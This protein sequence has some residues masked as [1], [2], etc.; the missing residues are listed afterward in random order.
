MRILAIRGRNLASLPEFALEL[1]RPPLYETGIFA[2]TGP[3]GAGKSTLLDALCLALYDR[4]PRLVGTRGVPTEE[5]G[6]GAADARGLL[7]RGTG[8]GFAEVDFVGVDGAHYRARWEVWRARRQPEGRLQDQRVALYHLPAEGPPKDLSEGRRTDT[9][10]AI[11][12][13]VGLEFDAFRR[14]VLLAQGDFA[15]FLRARP[16]ERAALLE[17]MTGTELYAELSRA[18]FARARDVRAELAEATARIEAIQPLAERA[19]A[20]LEA[21]SEHAAAAAREAEVQTEAHRRSAEWWRLH[22]GLKAELD[23][24]LDQR[25]AARSAASELPSLRERLG[26]LDALQR[27]R[28]KLEAAREADTRLEATEIEHRAATRALEA[29]TGHAETAELE[30]QQAQAAARRATEARQIA[31]PELE[32]ARALD[33]A[34]ADREAALARATAEREK[35]EAERAKLEARWAALDERRRGFEAAE[36]EDRGWWQAHA[37]LQDLDAAAQRLEASEARIAGQRRLADA[38]QR[39]ADR[40][41]RIE[42]A[43]AEAEKKRA[44]LTD[45]ESAHAAAVRA[46]RVAEQAV[47]EA[48]EPSG[49]AAARVLLERLGS[50]VRRLREGMAERRRRRREAAELEAASEALP[51]TEPEDPSQLRIDLLGSTLAGADAARARD[52]LLVPEQPC[53]LCGSPHHPFVD[54][55]PAPRATDPAEVGSALEALGEARARA[56]ALAERRARLDAESAKDRD[57]LERLRTELAELWLESS[58]LHGLGLTRVGLLLPRRPPE[59]SEQLGRALEALEEVE[60]KF[61]ASQQRGV[62]AKEALAAARL[63]A[64]G[65]EG[66]LGEARIASQ[67]AERALEE[68]RRALL[69]A[70]IQLGEAKQTLEAL[71]P[72]PE[73]PQSVEEAREELEHAR[74]R[75]AEA[76][77]RAGRAEELQRR[78]EEL[79]VELQRQRQRVQARVDQQAELHTQR[80]A[81]REAR[82]QLL[83]GAPTDRVASR[84]EAA[85]SEA[86]SAL[87]ASLDRRAGVRVTLSEARTSARLREEAHREALARATK[88]RSALEAALEAEAPRPPETLRALAAQPLEASEPLERRIATL[89]AA[90]ARAETTTA[91]RSDR[92]KAHEDLR[93]AQGPDTLEAAEQALR[94][95]ELRLQRSRDDATRLRLEREKDDEA[96]AR[97]LALEAPLAEQSAQALVWEELSDLIGSADGKKLRAFA[98]SLSLDALVTRANAHL[99]QL[100]PRYRLQRVTRADMELEVVDTDMGDEVRPIA[101]LSG[102]ETFLVSL[103][104]ALGLSD[105]SSAQIEV[106]SLF[107]D[108][109]FGALDPES[110]DVVLTALDQ[111]QASGR[112]VAMVSH[113]ADVAERLGFEVRVRPVAPGRSEV[114]VRG[115]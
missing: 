87:E 20:Q 81:E 54:A 61:D 27:I 39:C 12:S 44:A 50:E 55:P 10:K 23:A 32:K 71:G 103:A 98:Q 18:A 97:R 9:S 33:A 14:A 51:A 85:E 38:A 30:A 45:R 115:P 24:A 82:S 8:E 58:L 89:E 65:S 53:P 2:I 88:A 60:A 57:K 46:L 5:D 73:G 84:L 37:H 64:T 112:R 114:R 108:E 99:T 62:Q 90:L 75:R 63:A 102:G 110:L 79:K 7:R 83:E 21:D 52:A 4:V 76:S 15:A 48:S 36:A 68:A 56:R 109:G 78:E 106:E 16:D 104:L 28:P 107:V 42:E 31:Q 74:R 93:P 67:A 35:A 49:A 100:R 13:R 19:R 34:L 29:A 26:A 47:A 113:V 22:R 70:E 95:A 105:L 17:R 94:E 66:R 91:D 43:E 111:L 86:R 1:D 3:T 101:S 69:D 25:D 77:A 92:L 6:I 80:D 41:G 59:R 96:R 11:A 72:G 40:R